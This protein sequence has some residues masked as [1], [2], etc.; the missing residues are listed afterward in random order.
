MDGN[1]GIVSYMLQTLQVLVI[2]S[3]YL[4]EILDH[5][6]N[7]TIVA[8]PQGANLNP[9]SMPVNK[10]LSQKSKFDVILNAYPKKSLGNNV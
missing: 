3:A 4:N 8:S 1:G 5:N 2:A 10:R 6:T 9:R 7:I